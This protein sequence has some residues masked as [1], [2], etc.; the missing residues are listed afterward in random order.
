VATTKDDSP[1]GTEYTQG[2]SYGGEGDSALKVLRRDIDCAK[3]LPACEADSSG[4]G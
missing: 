2:Y 3:G 4:T 1:T